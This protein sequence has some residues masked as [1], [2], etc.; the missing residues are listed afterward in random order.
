MISSMIWTPRSSVGL[1]AALSAVAVAIAPC[2]LAQ[3]RAARAARPPGL[4]EGVAAVVNDNVI[5][6][7]DLSQR[8]R[9]L[10]VT[11]GVRPTEENL[12][13]I[14]REALRSLVD[15][16]L[17]LQEVRREEKEQKFKIMADDNDVS[18]EVE[19]L[20]QNSGMTG[21]QLLNALA[22]A[23]VSP[24]TLREQ[25][26]AQ[27][28]W[29]RWIQGRYGGSRLKI[30]QDRI[31]A[32]LRQIAAEAAKPQYQIAEIFIDSARAGGLDAATKGA[33]QIITQLQQGAPFQAVARQFSSASTAAN[34][35]DAGWLTGSQL[36]PEVRVVVE[37][38]R[39]GSLSQPIPVRDG[40][41]IIVLRDKRAGAGSELV[42]LKQAA[43]ALPAD[44][45]PEQV[46]AARQKLLAL[47]ARVTDCNSLTPEAAKVE[48]VVAGDL[49]EADPK[50]LAPSFRD[51]AQALKVGQI[52]DPLRTQVGLH[53]VALCGRR[54]AGVNL[55]PREDIE[56]RLED[57]QLS[58]F[59]KRYLRDLRTSALIE[60]R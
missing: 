47:K 29:A 42:T 39:P 15:E 22:G 55:P 48:G 44:A 18:R 16:R 10:L 14:E 58:Q 60:T 4:S 53:L 51:A 12:P 49:G 35:G 21:Q 41:Y 54:Q 50:D 6:T 45:S 36:P 19:R 46:E 24:T 31:S 33:E 43:I 28:S 57:E 26:R 25:L 37:Q 11:S 9:L 32:V 59:S 17:E 20:A 38:M 8:V 2:A 34:G 3:D 13:Q 52:S 7:F 1:A 23:G 40:V 27:V 56:A 5:S 30:S